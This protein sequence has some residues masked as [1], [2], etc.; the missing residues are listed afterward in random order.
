MNKIKLLIFDL[1]GTLLNTVADLAYSVNHA[2]KSNA[3]PVHPTEA[4]KTFV[5]NGVNKLIER[6]LPEG[7]KTPENIALI[8][9]GFRSYY[10]MHS[11]DYTVPYEGIPELL[12]TLQNEGYMLA[13]ASNKYHEAT[14]R[15]IAMFFPDVR[16]VAVLGQREGVPPKPDP[17]IV[18]D[19]LKT[20]GVSAAETLYVGD[21]A[22]DMQTAQNSH[23]TSV[24]VTWGFRPREE[25][26]AADACCI[27]ENPSDI[28][29]ILEISNGNT[30]FAH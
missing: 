23:I 9:E 26:I 2:L 13:V 5:G 20:A 21:S 28:K 11:A 22:V 25:L 10:D 6:A 3:F 4:Y 16:F 8:K 1:D 19:I 29:K 27:A 30:T 24:G 12:L 7:A 17:T 14:A 18:F 15:L